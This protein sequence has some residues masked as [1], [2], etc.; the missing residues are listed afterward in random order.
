MAVVILHVNK[1]EKKV[2]RLLKSGGLHE[3]HVVATWKLGNDL[4]IQLVDTGKPRKTCVEVAGRRTF[5]LLTS[6]Q[7]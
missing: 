1:Y 5:R 3:R 4:S 2:T 7:Q 6:S